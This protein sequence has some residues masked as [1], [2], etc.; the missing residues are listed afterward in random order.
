[1][2]FRSNPAFSEM[3]GYEP[4]E[5][6]QHVDQLWPGLLH[7]DERES[8]LS[9][10]ERQLHEA[11]HYEMEFRLRC[12]DGSYNWILSRGTVFERDE[13]G[14][15][16]RALGTHIDLTIRKQMETEL[17]EAK[18]Y[19]EAAN[20][21]KSQFL[22]NMGHELRTPLNGMI[23][24]TEVVREEVVEPHAQIGRAHV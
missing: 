3:L 20:R 14:F 11:G 17:R 6:G 22:A 19:A 24:L 23:G 9:A 10:T 7:P 5:L 15:P 8:V 18:D 1:M 4:G 21:A 12:K 16:V 13:A 2:L